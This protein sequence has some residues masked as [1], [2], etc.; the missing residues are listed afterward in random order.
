MNVVT[1]TGRLVRD[2]EIR[3]VGAK[4]TSVCDFTL[5]IDQNSYA[6]SKQANTNYPDC[7]AWGKTAEFIAKYFKKGMKADLC[8]ELVTSTFTNK[9]GDKQKRMVVNVDKIQFG[10]SRAS[11]ERTEQHD[12]EEPKRQ[13]EPESVPVQEEPKAEPKEAPKEDPKPVT[14]KADDT[15]SLLDEA[16]DDFMDI[17]EDISSDEMPFM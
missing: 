16:G 13:K 4:K 14:T 10:E 7:Q 3:E 6:P 8:G 1:L 17:P 2:P 12:V 5:A 11:Y 9:S 15:Q